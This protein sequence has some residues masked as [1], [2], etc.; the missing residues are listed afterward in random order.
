MT[1]LLVPLFL[2]NSVVVIC[3][4]NEIAIF[5]FHFNDFP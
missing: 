2:L 3:M 4:K 1:M 5:A